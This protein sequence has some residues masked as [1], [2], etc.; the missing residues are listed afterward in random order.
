[1]PS[2]FHE[3]PLS[4]DNEVIFRAHVLN[5]IALDERLQGIIPL[6]VFGG[7]NTKAGVV[8]R[9]VAE[10][11]LTQSTFIPE[12]I[13]NFHRGPQSGEGT[14]AASRPSSKPARCALSSSSSERAGP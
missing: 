8:P 12:S 5:G 10:R 7:A 3:L 1:M 4:K 11:G 6:G 9:R 14:P 13:M 2:P